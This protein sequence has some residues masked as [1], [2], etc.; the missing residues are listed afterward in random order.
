MSYMYD[1][2]YDGPEREDVAPCGHTECYGGEC[3]FTSCGHTACW[4][5]GCG[6]GDCLEYEHEDETNSYD[7]EHYEQAYCEHDS[8]P[9]DNCVKECEHEICNHKGD[10]CLIP[11][12]KWATA[13]C[14]NTLDNTP[15][16][17]QKPIINDMDNICKL[18]RERIEVLQEQIRILSLPY[19][20]YLSQRNIHPS[21][22]SHFPHS[23]RDKE[24]KWLAWLLRTRKDELHR[25][26]HPVSWG[27]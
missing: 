20:E 22:L 3:S 2:D 6:Y 21:R 1:E 15:S 13:F 23:S 14:M 17:I 16:E 8:C 27:N 11:S 26:Q 9:W 7:D 25:I 24:E 10:T 4:K 18:P 12:Q 19:E 5:A